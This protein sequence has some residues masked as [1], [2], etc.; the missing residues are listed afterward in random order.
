MWELPAIVNRDIRTN[1]K[2]VVH[3]IDRTLK[4]LTKLDKI[5]GIAFTF[6]TVVYLS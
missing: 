3:N 5:E 6:I 1:V 2:H 4:I